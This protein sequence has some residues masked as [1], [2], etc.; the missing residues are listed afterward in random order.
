METPVEASQALQTGMERNNN[1]NNKS[2]QSFSQSMAK[3]VSN[4]C[5]KVKKKKV[6][7][8]AILCQTSLQWPWHQKQG[9]HLWHKCLLHHEPTFCCSSW[10]ES[11]PRWLCT[12]E[13]KFKAKCFCWLNIDRTAV[14][15][16]QMEIFV[17]FKKDFFLPF[18]ADLCL[19]LQSLKGGTMLQ[20]TSWRLLGRDSILKTFVV[21]QCVITINTPPIFCLWFANTLVRQIYFWG[22]FINFHVL[23]NILTSFETVVQECLWCWRASY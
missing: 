16:L 17:L 22:S 11:E 1:N 21:G 8:A 12:E 7:S 5:L 23:Y 20:K 13:L 6:I 10:V 3:F 4:W 19:Q 9:C 2:Q 15:N 14:Q 18:E